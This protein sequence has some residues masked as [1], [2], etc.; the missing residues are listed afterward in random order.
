MTKSLIA[1][2]TSTALLA[3]CNLA[4]NYERPTG[5]IPATL[6][7]GGVYPAA[8]TD[9]VDVSRIGSRA[10]F[11]DPRLQQVIEAGLAHNRDLRVA[12]ANVLP[13]RPQTKVARQCVV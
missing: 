8:A 7:Q 10:F 5:A 11:L 13:A 4:P 6:P 9:A 2:I 1:L 12:T 3:G